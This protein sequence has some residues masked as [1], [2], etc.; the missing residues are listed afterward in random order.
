[1]PI[2]KEM[3]MLR[4][5]II[6]VLCA[7]L[8]LSLGFAVAACT[9]AHEHSYT[10]WAHSETEH[11]K[12]CPA[13]GAEE[14]GSRAQHVFDASFHCACGFTHTHSYTAWAHSETEH[15]KICPADGVEEPGSRA[16]HVF[17]DGRC[18]CNYE[19]NHV[20]TYS[21]WGYSDDEHWRM[22]PD[23]G[24]EQSGTRTQ[25]SFSDYV[26][27]KN[28]TFGAAGEKTRSC[29]CGKTE[30][31]EIP[32]LTEDSVMDYEIRL[33]DPYGQPF[34]GSVT[35]TV[36]FTYGDGE[37]PLDENGAEYFGERITQGKHVRLKAGASH[38]VFTV[39]LSGGRNTSYT[40]VETAVTVSPENP[41]AV[42]HIR[43]NPPA[44]EPANYR[45]GDALY[46]YTFTSVKGDGATLT[47]PEL[48][49]DHKVVLLSFFYVG[50]RYCQIELPAIL[51]VY[52]EYRNE[53]AIVFLNTKTASEDTDAE[54]V[55]W[56]GKYGI[57]DFF[58]AR[59]PFNYNKLWAGPYGNNQYT[60]VTGVPV[61]LFVDNQG[62]ILTIHPG[63]IGHGSEDTFATSVA[64]VYAV[65]DPVMAKVGWSR[66]TASA[67]SLEAMLPE[68]R[69][70]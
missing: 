60:P 5:K 32:A 47:L 34:R 35:L 25:H 11:W 48:Y 52:P 19:E 41:V 6:A 31:E 3:N 10:A 12:V 61:N 13:D 30:T 27:T 54:I 28:P 42:F 20:H 7:A 58:I 56:A 37:F 36:G 9:E 51:Q 40:V 67:A 69:K 18:E 43:S 63:A 46:N 15:W 8:G 59:M 4:K 49:A 65:F 21:A 2:D 66:P 29:E 16:G 17:H 64:D 39:T 44:T 50:C 45:E 14:P 57:S 62:T 70:D 33:L 68:K 38:G 26:V 55:E 24:A 22:C 23:D 53:M 1:M